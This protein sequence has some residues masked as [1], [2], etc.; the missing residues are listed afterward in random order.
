MLDC[1]SNIDSYFIQTVS[2]L[3]LI[4]SDNM[5]N[6][7]LTRTVAFRRQSS[8]SGDVSSRWSGPIVVY[9]IRRTNFPIRKLVYIQEANI[10][11]SHLPPPSGMSWCDFGAGLVVHQLLCM[12]SAHVQTIECSMVVW[13]TTRSHTIE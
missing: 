1:R 8:S 5:I 9:G 3:E 11:T 4:T 13:V 7:T 6:G 12:S 10:L 2:A